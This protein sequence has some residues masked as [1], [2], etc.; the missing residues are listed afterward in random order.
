MQE[1]IKPWREKCTCK[2]RVHYLDQSSMIPEQSLGNWKKCQLALSCPLM[3]TRR[4]VH[5]YE[6][7][8]TVT[9]KK[10]DLRLLYSCNHNMSIEQIA[11]SAPNKWRLTVL[12]S[13]VKLP[14]RDRFHC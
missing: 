1:K 5:H 13:T 10:S 6:C 2:Y 4:K 3:R 7:S 11:C 14:I 8:H 12:L 9:L